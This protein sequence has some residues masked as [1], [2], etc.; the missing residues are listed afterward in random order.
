VGWFLVSNS[1][2]GT[3]AMAGRTVREAMWDERREWIRK[4][5]ESGMSV[6][7]LC[8]DHGIHL[9]NFHA[10]RLRIAEL[11][12]MSEPK[13][14]AITETRSH[15]PF[16]KPTFLQVTIPSNAAF[17]RQETWVEVS[18]A[19]G[20]IVRVPSSNLAAIEAVVSSLNRLGAEGRT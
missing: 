13:S 19:S 14:E 5:R 4:Q 10:W 9:G 17:A 20:M 11:D 18:I 2:K 8:R 7:Q 16:A 6:A 12:A 3:F 15:G 1:P